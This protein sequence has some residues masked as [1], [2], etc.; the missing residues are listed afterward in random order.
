VSSARTGW[1]WEP[2][3]DGTR[4]NCDFGCRIA[5]NGPCSLGE[6]SVPTSGVGKD[7]WCA[8]HLSLTA[9][10]VGLYTSLHWTVL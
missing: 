6:A 3:G 8:L 5:R 1:H 7:N 10:E 4:G 9:E 2:R